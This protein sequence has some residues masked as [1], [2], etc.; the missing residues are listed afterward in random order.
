MSPPDCASVAVIQPAY[1]DPQSPRQTS[2][3]AAPRGPL[4]P[5]RGACPHRLCEVCEHRVSIAIR[6]SQTTAIFLSDRVHDFSPLAAISCVRRVGVAGDQVRGFHSLADDRFGAV[7]AVVAFG[8]AHIGHLHSSS[9]GLLL[10]PTP[11]PGDA[12]RTGFRRICPRVTIQAASAQY[13]ASCTR[14]RGG[15]RGENVVAQA[16]V[17]ADVGQIRG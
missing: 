11:R 2:W 16:R 13:A 7:L 3:T 12:Q 6:L 9:R 14:H 17:G 15:I 8:G 4:V 10:K 1:R 5:R